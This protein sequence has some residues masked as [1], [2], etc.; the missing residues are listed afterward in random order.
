VTAHEDVTRLLVRWKAG[1]SDAVDVLVPIIY[2]ELHKLARHYGTCAWSQIVSARL[3][4][5]TSDWAARR[6]EPD[7]YEGRAPAD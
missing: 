6:G 5:V 3:P 1:D 4:K 2:N 7:R